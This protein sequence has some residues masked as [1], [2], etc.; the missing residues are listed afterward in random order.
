MT[1]TPEKK[2]LLATKIL[3]VYFAACQMYLFVCLSHFYRENNK[4]SLFYFRCNENEGIVVVAI[5]R[6]YLH[7]VHLVRK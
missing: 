4:G 6:Q 7:T 3:S 1:N 2:G 5:N